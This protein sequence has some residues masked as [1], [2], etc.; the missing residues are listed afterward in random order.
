MGS[1]DIRYVAFV[2]HLEDEEGISQLVEEIAEAM[3]LE[4]RLVSK[5]LLPMDLAFEED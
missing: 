5:G 1:V 3:Y 2:V 4:Y